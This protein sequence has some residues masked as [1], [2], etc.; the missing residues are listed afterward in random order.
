MA[1]L[2]KSDPEQPPAFLSPFMSQSRE[3]L[4]TEPDQSIFARIGK[5]AADDTWSGTSLRATSHPNPFSNLYANPLHKNSLFRGTAVGAGLMMATGVGLNVTQSMGYISLLQFNVSLLALAG[6]VM[7]LGIVVAIA[8]VFRSDH[9]PR[10]AL[11]L[12]D[13]NARHSPIPSKTLQVLAGGEEEHLARHSAAAL[14]NLHAGADGAK[15]W[16]SEN[17]QPWRDQLDLRKEASETIRAAGSLQELRESLGDFPHHRGEE[18]QADWKADYAVYK[19]GLAAL[20]ERVEQQV[21]LQLAV[22]EIGR[23][24]ETPLD[25]RHS[26][27][28][29]I[30]SELP[31]YEQATETISEL[32]SQSTDFLGLLTLQGPTIDAPANALD[33]D[34]N[35][36]RRAEPPSGA[37]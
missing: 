2:S 18:D 34:Q 7:I 5:D 6:L 36:H 8:S 35:Q 15:A 26:L 24:F 4:E 3:K 20:R 1:D 25:A 29:R 9:R 28:D 12:L 37:R 16:K 30:A 19:S 17:L 27:A 31:S 14:W 33:D 13:T 11:V 21:A 22:E 32:N 10:P 23:Q